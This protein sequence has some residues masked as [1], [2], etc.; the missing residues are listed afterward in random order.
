MNLYRPRS[1]AVP[2]HKPVVVIV[3]QVLGSFTMFTIEW[4]DAAFKL[5]V[6][7]SFLNQFPVLGVIVSWV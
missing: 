4:P 5:I 6:S 2:Y 1:C 3:F 7:V